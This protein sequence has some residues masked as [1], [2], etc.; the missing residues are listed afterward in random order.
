MI[1]PIRHSGQ[2]AVVAPLIIFVVEFMFAGGVCGQQEIREQARDI[3]ARQGHTGTTDKQALLLSHIG[4]SGWSLEELE[5]ALIEFA[6]TDCLVT[7]DNPTS[8]EICRSSINVLSAMRVERSIET[9]RKVAISQDSVLRRRAIRALV[10]M[11][12]VES[13]DFAREITSRQSTESRLERGAVY[14]TLIQLLNDE[15][16]RSRAGAE[17]TRQVLLASV[18]AETDPANWV[19]LDEALKNLDHDYRLSHEREALLARYEALPIEILQAYVLDE[20]RSLRSVPEG[21]RTHFSPN[22]R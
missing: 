17:Q 1:S 8:W 18:T 2:D 11:G 22:K 3:L 10:G 20:L 19:I 13:L 16:L 5:N 21:K 9:L 12:F 6:S 4:T 14:E 7:T 15:A